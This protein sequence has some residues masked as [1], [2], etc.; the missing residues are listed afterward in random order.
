MIDHKLEGV[1]KR[2]NVFKRF[3]QQLKKL[4]VVFILMVVGGKCKK[5]VVQEEHISIVE[6]PGP[7]YFAHIVH[8]GSTQAIFEGLYDFMIE[9]GDYNSQRVN[10]LK[11]SKQFQSD[12]NICSSLV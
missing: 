8:V 5:Q 3:I 11:L 10:Y 2:E 7:K 9:K 4:V 1:V 6:E 12:E